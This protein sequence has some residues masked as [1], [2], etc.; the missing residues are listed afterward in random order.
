MLHPVVPTSHHRQPLQWHAISSSAESC[1]TRPAAWPKRRSSGRETW[2][3]S[4]EVEGRILARSLRISFGTTRPSRSSRSTRTI[5]GV[6][7]W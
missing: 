4:H 2:E 1:A 7:E 3:W 5:A 6:P